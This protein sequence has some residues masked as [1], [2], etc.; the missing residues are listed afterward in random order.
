MTDLSYV[1]QLIP[2][3]HGLSVIVTVRSGG[4]PQTSVVNAGVVSHPL[5]GEE[6][7]AFVTA[8]RARK[9]AYLRADPRV[10][11]ALRAGWQWAAIEGTAE[12]IGPQDPHEDIDAEQLRLL[13]REIFAAAGGDHDDWDTYDRVMREEQ[14]TAVLVTPTRV[15]TNPQ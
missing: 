9:L 15:Y 1:K 11:V 3:D 7:V 5:T 12:L 6:I 2:L 4:T 10:T 13:L 14:R 8:G